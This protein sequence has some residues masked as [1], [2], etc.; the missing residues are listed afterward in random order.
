MFTARFQIFR[1][2]GIPIRVDLSWFAIVALI[3]W[4]LRTIFPDYVPGLS[5]AT[6][7]WMGFA[8]ALGLFASILLHELAHALVARKNGLEM[9]GITLFVFGGVAEMADEP[10]SAKVEFLVAIA[11]PIASVLIAAVCSGLAWAG[12]T[13]A[14]PT[15]VVSVLAYLGWMNAVVVGFNLI[16][17]FPLDGGRVF[18]S[19]L[20][21]IRGNLR[22]ATR[23]TS[24]IGSGFGLALMILGALTFMGGNPIGGMWQFLIGMFLRSAAQ[25][26]YQQ[27][28]IRRALE[29]ETVGRFMQSQVQTVGPTITVADLVEQY[30]YKQHHKLYPVVD[31]SRLLGC[32]TTAEVKQVAPERWR[33][34]A[35]GD[36]LQPC[37]EMNTIAPSADAM[38]ALSR[39]SQAQ[40]SRLMV[41]EENHLY[42][43]VTLKDL[44]QFIS[45]KIELDE[46]HRP[47]AGGPS[48]GDAQD[49]EHFP[50]RA[51]SASIGYNDSAVEVGAGDRI[52]SR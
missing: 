1:L 36:I 27:L 4:T 3:T 30:M 8:G 39:M 5:V 21:Q 52:A 14:W 32:V 35:V 26:S 24:M 44:M 34:V 15:P 18:R 51:P 13:A 25:M 33:L 42:G 38:Q 31:G 19:L 23:V 22:W 17:A 12:G 29:G 28:I 37:S 11:G 47:S 46:G 48:G 6:Y 43:I 2:A 7:W 10:P 16:P 9:K 45:L 49:R 41:V 40:S 20:W 50:P